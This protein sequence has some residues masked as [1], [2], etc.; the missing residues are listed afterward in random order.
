MDSW[1]LDANL[2]TRL[3]SSGAMDPMPTSHLPQT[4]STWGIQNAKGN[5]GAMVNI[6]HERL[7]VVENG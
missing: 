4:L 3:N 5:Q 7:R 6:G 2:S 1:I